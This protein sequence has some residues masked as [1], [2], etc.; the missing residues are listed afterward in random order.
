MKDDLE[1]FRKKLPEVHSN[2]FTHVSREAFE[3]A[4]A[5]LQ[6]KT[7]TLSIEKFLVE[8]FKINALIA[9]EHTIINPDFKTVF[10]L[11]FEYFEEGIAIIASDST[12]S[13]CLMSR[14]LSLNA[15]PVQEAI[16]LFSSLFKK[17]NPSFQK[18]WINSYFNKPLLLKGLGLIDDESTLH[19][20]LLT[21]GGDTI[22]RTI[23][24]V[25]ADK[26]FVR[27]K[28]EP[29]NLLLPYKHDDFYWYFMDTLTNSLYFNYTKCQQDEKLSFRKFNDRLF[30][31]IA[32]QKPA[33]LIIDLR[34]N[35]GGNSA[36]LKPFIRDI[37]NSYLNEKGKLYVII[38]RKTFS[39][40]LMNAVE[41]VRETNAI[42]VGEPTGANI[43]H[44][45]EIKSFR[46]QY[47]GIT[48]YYATK[49]WTNWAGHD[50]ALLPDILLQHRFSNFMHNTDEALEFILKQ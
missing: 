9:D 22:S 24:A 34:F 17:D 45:G 5:D 49:Y 3:T 40:A 20:K 25:P 15:H 28:S 12:S 6:K 10:P 38:G 44:F 35:G 39:S 13:D 19:L 7:D 18:F 2:P 43:N 23:K 1:Y 11:R 46:L 50:G 48:V 16:Q 36:I 30:E 26:P 14:V 32:K 33:K 29:L 21:A 27:E 31:E 41:L 8:L 37:K 4:V 47:S 42:T